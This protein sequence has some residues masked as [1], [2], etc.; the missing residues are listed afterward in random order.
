[1][2]II[3]CF[4]TI[5]FLGF[6]IGCNEQKD[7]HLI[8]GFNAPDL[9]SPEKTVR[10]FWWAL[11]NNKVDVAKN[12]IDL[13]KVAIGRHGTNIDKFISNHQKTN[14][15]KFVF[16]LADKLVRIKSPHHCM[17]YDLEMNGENNWIIVSMHP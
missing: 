17:D 2:R 6:S 1:M 12:C 5:L 9:S 10:S 14:T 13:E 3:T 4:S 11:K 8:N 16:I 7:I 15:E